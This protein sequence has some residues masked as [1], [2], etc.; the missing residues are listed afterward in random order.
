M[1]CLVGF[2]LWH[3]ELMLGCVVGFDLRHRE[4]M[5]GCV[6]GFDLWHR[7]LIHNILE[8]AD[9]LI[10]LGQKIKAAESGI[11]LPDLGQ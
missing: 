4:L 8:Q 10:A 9:Y 2:D 6:F 5:L 1:G 11:L 3:R 7:E